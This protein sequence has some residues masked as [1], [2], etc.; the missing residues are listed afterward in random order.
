[1]K[2]KLRLITTLRKDLG[3][4]FIGT[5]LTI[6]LID[7]RLIDIPEK[8]VGGYK[9]GQIIYNLCLSYVSAFI[10]YFLVV[11]IKEQ[12]D[13]K[14]LYP[15]LSKKVYKVIK[16]ALELISELAKAS[17][18]TIANK[19]PTT[20]ELDS[21]CK[22]VN[23]NTNAPLLSGRR[24]YPIWIQYFNYLIKKSNNA[25]DKIFKK[26]Q[27]LDTELVNML[28]EI[29]DSDFFFIVDYMANKNEPIKDSDLTFLQSSISEY[30]ELIIQLEKYADNK[31]ANY[32]KN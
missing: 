1:M 27:F 16:N 13:K 14:N 31:L 5:L 8:F 20:S 28:A 11:H 32:K 7:F 26:M 10:F 17:N 25:T 15:Y 4:L 2:N 18:T 22:N 23:L 9:L 6:F 3:C 12:E 19:Y 29:E 30:F 21:M 24:N